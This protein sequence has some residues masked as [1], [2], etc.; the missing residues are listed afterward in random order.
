MTLIES[1]KKDSAMGDESSMMQANNLIEG[2]DANAPIDSINAG[3]VVSDCR[4]DL[5]SNDVVEFIDFERFFYLNLS[6][7]DL[8]GPETDLVK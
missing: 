2:S 1:T 6:F 5:P 4:I 3:M 8:N 7:G